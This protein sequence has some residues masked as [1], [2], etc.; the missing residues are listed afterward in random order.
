MTTKEKFDEIIKNT[1]Y[2]K[3]VDW[4]MSLQDDS[5]KY[6]KSYQLHGVMRE[7][8]REVYNQG[9]K[10]S[11]EALPDKE[12]L[13]VLIYNWDAYPKSDKM[14]EEIREEAINNINKLMR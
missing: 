7:A 5:L 6:N 13:E 4:E 2:A 3:N 8:L 9:V 14:A 12:T 11:V 10:D 1:M